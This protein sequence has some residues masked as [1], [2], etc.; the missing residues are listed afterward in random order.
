[1]SKHDGLWRFWK[2]GGGVLG[3]LILLA[4]LVAGNLLVGAVRLRHDLTED[5]LY[6]LSDN[7]RRVLEQLELPV[8]LKFFFTS[9]APEVPVPLKYFA[10]QVEDLLREYQLAGGG[11]VLLEIYNPEPDTEIEEWAE[12]YGLQGQQLDM[13]GASFYLGLVAAQGEHYASMPFI[14]PREETLL[15]YNITRMI[16]R[17]SHP[18]K[19][20]VGVLSSL[21]VMGAQA[22]PYQMG[23]QNTGQRQWAAFRHLAEDYEVRILPEMTDEIGEDIDVLVLVHPK[24]LS[25]QTQYAIDQFVLRGGRLLALLDPMCIADAMNDEQSRMTGM[26]PQVSSDLGLLAEAWGVAWDPQQVVADFTASTQV[27]QGDG[28]LDDSPVFLSL[29]QSNFAREDVLM[30][31]L[32]GIVMPLAGAFRTQPVD[33]VKATPLIYSSAQAQAV[34]AMLAQMGSAALR[35]S[36]QPEGAELPLA[37]RLHGEFTTAFPDGPPDAD[38]ESATDVQGLQRSAMPTTIVLVGDVDMLHDQFAV[39]ELNLFGSS[40]FQPINDNLSFFVNA[41]EQL[42]G[43]VE[44]AEIRTRGRI[45]RPFTRVLAL[46]QAAQERWMMQER[47]L[48]QRLEETRQRLG[49]L[50]AGRDQS[51]GLILS[52]EQEREI[53][54]FRDEQARTRQ[55]LRKV[56]RNLREGIERLGFKVKLI[57]ILLMPVLV[58]LA[59]IVFAW[60]RQVRAARAAADA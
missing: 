39:Q 29:R 9:T 43:A 51:Q 46:Q 31:R 16:S 50:Q 5:K 34:P 28:G 15:E 30:A 33:G 10:Q 7:S 20:L 11:R 57:N 6:T 58:G 32:H 40:V 1:M 26:P 49:E 13:L 37:L 36:F 45:E 52:P 35:R 55:E 27:R 17:V 48:Q 47:A 18:Q 38:A 2:V 8:T 3:L 42:S 54:Q 23:P 59:G 25:E 53:E 14:D 41:V 22:L 4:I 21:P 12:R 24:E 19:P 60:R 44:L 56:R